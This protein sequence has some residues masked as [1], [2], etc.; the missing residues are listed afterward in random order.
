MNR[1]SFNP[2][3]CSICRLRVAWGHR[4]KGRRAVLSYAELAEEG[5][6]RGCMQAT[7]NAIEAYHAALEHGRYAPAAFTETVRFLLDLEH[8]DY[9]KGSAYYRQRKA[10]FRARRAR[11]SAA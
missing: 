3:H 6:L 9:R 2:A 4:V 10:H 5:Q 7:G 1:H 8:G 11:V